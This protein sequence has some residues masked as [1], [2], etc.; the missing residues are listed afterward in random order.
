MAQAST[1]RLLT[2]REV[3]DRLGMSAHWVLDKAEAGELP[4]FKLGRAVRFDP[5]AIET[6]L[7]EQ[8]R[9]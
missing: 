9:S 5:T 3:A 4:S 1:A 7:A 2:A 6:W 8:R